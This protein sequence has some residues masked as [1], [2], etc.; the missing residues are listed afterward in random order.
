MRWPFSLPRRSGESTAASSQVSGETGPVTAEAA[1]QAERS[2]A[3][4]EPL[5]S[6]FGTAPLTVRPSQFIAGL[7]VSHGITPTLRPLEHET[8]AGG[9]VGVI[10][11]LTR[12][13]MPRAGGPAGGAGTGSRHG[14][15]AAVARD[16]GAAARPLVNASGFGAVP[17]TPAG[18]GAPAGFGANLG[19]DGDLGARRRLPVV[20][21]PA[22]ERS[23]SYTSVDPAS[24]PGW[25]GGRVHLAAGPGGRP[26]SG[27][28]A[29]AAALSDQAGSPTETPGAA[30]T[31]PDR[32]AAPALGGAVAAPA[33]RMSG[34][35]RPTPVGGELSLREGPSHLPVN[36]VRRV[37]LGAPLAAMPGSAQ[38]RGLDASQLLRA[39]GPIA[40]AA[41]FA[42]TAARRSPITGGAARAL[43]IL[44]V[45]T[46][47]PTGLH[48]VRDRPDDAGRENV[49]ARENGT[50][51]FAPAGPA[52]GLPASPSP[53]PAGSASP[54]AGAGGARSNSVQR[55]AI[56][57]PAELLTHS[58]AGSSPRAGEGQTWPFPS[59]SSGAP[60]PELPQPAMAGHPVL[61]LAVP[62]SPAAPSPQWSGT[63][64]AGG[65]P[66]IQRI[67]DPDSARPEAPAGG[68][69]NV[70]VARAA[71]VG[72]GASPGATAAA[73]AGAQS[74]PDDQVEQ[75]AGRIYWRIRDRLGAELLRDRERAGL[76]PDR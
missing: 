59:S 15:H 11:G 61:S 27:A 49:A 25:S 16:A 22:A 37:G 52:R 71:D 63:P 42:E 8:A 39:T 18:L 67:H 7:A 17:G 68:S 66:V 20:D 72:G 69:G 58:V 13:A 62:P 19:A 24:D 26:G 23:H 3:A 14:P 36:R 65:G 10:G 74:I 38:P 29:D 51:S 56:G 50:T 45:A 31:A 6:T 30:A 1:E 55:S 35:V 9:P 43:P 44:P 54:A 76:L 60:V 12:P 64:A 75:L 70:L 28:A 47:S 73:A 32:A 57:R 4:I 53:G 46:L 40:G 41:A 33:P 5:Q 34:E 48:P 21:L 2:A